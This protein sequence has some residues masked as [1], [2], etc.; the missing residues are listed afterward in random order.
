MS[1][2]ITVN[3]RTTAFPKIPMFLITPLLPIQER[4]TPLIEPAII[5]EKTTSSGTK[6]IPFKN[7]I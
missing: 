1:G 2:P 7:K 3:I 6:S 5:K 4:I